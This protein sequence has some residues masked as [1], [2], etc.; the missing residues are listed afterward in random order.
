MT[1]IITI[2]LSFFT[3]GVIIEKLSKKYCPND[4][5]VM[6]YDSYGGFECPQCG[7]YEKNGTI[8]NEGRI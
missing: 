3:I 6:E 5:M 7:R 2:V 4:G 8:R 1:T